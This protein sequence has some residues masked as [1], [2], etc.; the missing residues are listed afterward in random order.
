MTVALKIVIYTDGCLK[1]ATNPNAL[2]LSV[3]LY[4]RHVEVMHKNNL[5]ELMNG[6]IRKKLKVIPDCVKWGGTFLSAS[7]DLMSVL[8]PSTI[9]QSEGR[10]FI[11][12]SSHIKFSLSSILK[13][14]FI[15][16]DEN[17]TEQ[18]SGRQF[19]FYCFYL[20]LAKQ[21]KVQGPKKI[22]N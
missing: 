18:A 6:P 9:L 10:Y 4:Q 22:L 7:V 13:R 2:S 3:R 16:T 19:W 12:V 8:W 5:S 15:V 11:V 17:V 20:S 21:L 14:G 1:C